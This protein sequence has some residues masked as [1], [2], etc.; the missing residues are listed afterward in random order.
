MT[1][2][3]VGQ[4]GIA[5]MGTN[6]EVWLTAATGY[7]EI[8]IQ[9]KNNDV[10]HLSISI[11]GLEFPFSGYFPT[12]SSMG[13][14][15]NDFQEKENLISVL[16]EQKRKKNVDSSIPIQDL[17]PDTRTAKENTVK[18]VGG[19]YD[20]KSNKWVTSEESNIIL[21][22]IPS[23]WTMEFVN[24]SLEKEFTEDSFV[25]EVELPK[26]VTS[27]DV[28]KSFLLT[29]Y[30]MFVKDMEIKYNF[31]LSDERRRLVARKLLL[32]AD[33]IQQLTT[34][35][36]IPNYKDY[37]HTKSRGLVFQVIERFVPLDQSIE[38]D[39]G[40]NSKLKEAMTLAKSLLQWQ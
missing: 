40:L 11:P 27:T 25:P 38:T 12:N 24:R 9:K 28:D 1:L 32:L 34:G 3:E 36:Q 29:N 7:P 23:E 16:F 5:V 17:K 39:E 30:Y 8:T 35:I 26:P 10:S 15:L 20:W 37:S 19:L 14:I 18:T 13:K 21:E 33:G 31:N 22:N 2:K 6:G 4:K